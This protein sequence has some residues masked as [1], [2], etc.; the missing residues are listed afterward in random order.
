MRS[1]VPEGEKTKTADAAAA[2]ARKKMGDDGAYKV[3]D[4]VYITL[5]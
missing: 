3:S 2:A 1:S 4:M 5:I